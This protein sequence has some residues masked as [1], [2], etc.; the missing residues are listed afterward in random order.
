LRGGLANPYTQYINT[1]FHVR[2]DRFAF[3]SV[4]RTSTFA[5]AVEK[6]FP[7]ERYTLV[8]IP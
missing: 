7:D 5:V 8:I 4:T 1:Q 2:S 3:T 6:R